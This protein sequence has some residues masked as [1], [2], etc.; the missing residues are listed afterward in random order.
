MTTT[1]DHAQATSTATPSR[2]L[3]YLPTSALII[4]LLLMTIVG[5]VAIVGR[6]HLD[7][8]ASS[9]SVEEQV[10]IAG[11]LMILGWIAALVILGAY[12]RDVFGVGTD[13]YRRVLD[14]SLLAAGITGV[15]SYLVKFDLSRGFFVLAYGLGVPAL[16]LGRFLLRRALHTARRRGLLRQRVLIS[17]TR[18]HVDEIAGVLGREP[19]LGYEVIGALTPEYDLSEETATGL[20][21]VGNSDEV[22]SLVAHHRADAIF[23]AGGAVGSS[24]QFRR[25]V[26]DLEQSQVQVVIA[27]SVTDVSNERISIRPVGGLPLMHIEPPTWSDASRWGKRAFDLFGSAVLIMAFAPLF[28]VV[29]LQIKLHDRGPVFFRHNRVGRNGNEFSCFKFRTMIQDAEALVTGLQE[30]HGASALLFKMKDDPRITPPGRWM[31]RLSVDELPQLFNV[32]LGHMSLVGP[33]PQV[34]RE[35]ALYD[36]SMSRRLHVRPGM[37]GLW[38]VSGRNDLTVEEAVRLDLYY[39]DNWSMLQDLSILGRT[40]GAVLS[41]RGA[42]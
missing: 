30:A 29:A 28:L 39:V 3:R 20:P 12:H 22:T 6:R 27:P 14:A 36:S 33:R 18:S 10:V 1:S 7:L 41:S 4:D 5:L 38:Q 13:E 35:V 31:R 37:T 34:A 40:V 15:G 25:V 21:V 17:G 8:F 24:A 26:W 23:F 11:P 16:F 42:Y 2:M 19:W 32:F 9:A